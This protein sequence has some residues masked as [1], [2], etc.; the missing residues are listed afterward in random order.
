M[1]AQ[2]LHLFG[3]TLHSQ[4]TAGGPVYHVPIADMAGLNTKLGLLQ[5]AIDDAAEAEANYRSKVA[6][7]EAKRQEVVDAVSLVAKSIYG[8]A[9]LTD[10]LIAATGLAVHDHGPSPVVPQEPTELAAA[11]FSNGTVDLRWE[12]N[13]NPY[14]VVFVVETSPD[15]ANWKFVT[16]TKRRR[17]TLTEFQPGTLAWF[18]VRA[19]T[20]AQQSVWSA[21]ASIYGPVEPVAL[22]LAA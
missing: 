11:A 5:T 8:D 12:R 19:T 21:S 3:A 13:G 18:R 9:T 4:V 2:P 10:A 14:G 7:K 16:S 22:T 17:L 20:A 15:G 1:G 6:N